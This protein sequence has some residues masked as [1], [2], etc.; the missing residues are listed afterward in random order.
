MLQRLTVAIV[1]I[2]VASLSICGCTS[3]TSPSPSPTAMVTNTTATTADYSSYYD[4]QWESAGLIITQPF[5]KSTNERGNDVYTGVAKNT[6]QSKMGSS[7]IVIELTSSQAAAKQIYDNYVSNK[8]K[9]G[10][11]AHPEMTAGKAQL[12]YTD[13][14]VG[15][16]GANNSQL[17]YVMYRAGPAISL[18]EVTTEATNQ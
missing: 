3:T 16:K 7:T 10:F 1:V 8:T 13:M 15:A 11:T 2:V 6:S 12:G 14:W 4:K 9:Q 17:F 5:T 18:W